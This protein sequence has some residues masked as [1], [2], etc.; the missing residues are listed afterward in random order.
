MTDSS[1]ASRRPGGPPL[2]PLAIV[3]FALTIAGVVVLLVGT[4]S[5]PAPF[6]SAADVASWYT[7]HALPIRIAATLQL[8]AA[9]PLGILAASIY[10]R[11]LR[12]GVRVPGPVIGLYGGIGASLL[13]L[14]SALVTWALASGPDAADPGSA[15]TLGRLAF[16]LGGVGYAVG[17]GL[18][19]AGIA[20]PAFI[21]RLIPRRL[22]LAGLV[23]AAV[24]E[25]SFLSLVIDPLQALLP[26]VRFGG[27]A[28]LIAATFLLP[29][30]RPRRGPRTAAAEDAS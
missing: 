24:G 16:G 19:I 26:I 22:A 8:G 20:V 11:Q 13:L 28:W 2:G 7:A 5:V 27:G 18:L 6:A 25:L 12:L 10:A 17:M 4:G 21:L 1:P 23:L 15:A 30:D 9:V 14:V 3:T 29:R